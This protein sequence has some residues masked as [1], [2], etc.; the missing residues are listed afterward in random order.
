MTSATI[1]SKNMLLDALNSDIQNYKYNEDDI[2]HYESVYSLF[3]NSISSWGDFHNMT[4]HF[5][6]AGDSDPTFGNAHF[7]AYIMSDTDRAVFSAIIIS[8][9]TGDVWS[10]IFTSYDDT[11]YTKKLS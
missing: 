4:Y 9:W 11:N 3:K 7:V 2:D 5:R 8:K 6:I 1:S 10:M